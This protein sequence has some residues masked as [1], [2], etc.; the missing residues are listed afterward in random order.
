[1]PKVRHWKN[2]G[3]EDQV[4][5]KMINEGTITKNTK[6][7]SLKDLNHAVFGVFSNNVIRNHLNE[8]KRRNGLYC[9]T[10][11]LI[12][13]RVWYKNAILI[14]VSGDPIEPMDD[15]EEN[16]G[17]NR[18]QDQVGGDES[19]TSSDS[20]PSLLQP[21]VQLDH[22][23]F[24]FVC[25]MY[26]DPVTRLDVVLIMVNLPGGAQNVGVELNNDGTV[27]TIKYNWAKA[28][29]NVKDLFKKFVAAKETTMVHP[30]VLAVEEALEK[31][32]SHIDSA[33]ESTMVI[34]LP[35]KV[36]T[37]PFTW[38]KNGIAREDGMQIVMVEF[39]GY[40]KEYH[41]VKENAIVV[42]DK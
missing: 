31:C 12:Y 10:L 16:D 3:K 18:Q 25:E 37:D 40:V 11:K 20:L 8:L 35:M 21:A 41:K 33:P 32:R 23:N 36:Q 34:K 26:K 4:V 39:V 9:K 2:G 27:V 22:H 6:G 19:G 1:M 24:P 14:L 28:W 30:M 7:S 38:K 15:K 29:Y 13:R 17:E 42:F 5:E